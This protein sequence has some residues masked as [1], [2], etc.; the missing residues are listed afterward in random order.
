[1]RHNLL[2]SLTLSCVLAACADHSGG[3]SAT[4]GTPNTPNSDGGGSASGTSGS[5]PLD[6]TT[7]TVVVG[8]G[9]GENTGEGVQVPDSQPGSPL[10]PL[11]S[12]DGGVGGGGSSGD[13]GDGGGQP[14]PEPGTLLLVGTGLAGVALLR[15]RRRTAHGD[16]D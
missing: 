8:G 15:R 4:G 14:V 1:M 7:D 16:R 12:T 13:G 2:I 10:D 11:D 3:T 6:K 5:S 9:A